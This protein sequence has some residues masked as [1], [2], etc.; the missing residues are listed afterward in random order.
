MFIN[1]LGENVSVIHEQTVIL[2]FID[3]KVVMLYQ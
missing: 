1:V 2:C 3:G